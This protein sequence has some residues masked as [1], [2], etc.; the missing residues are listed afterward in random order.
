MEAL[1]KVRLRSWWTWN[2]IW[3]QE[4]PKLLL[5]YSLLFPRPNFK[6]KLCDPRLP[7][8]TVTSQSPG[9]KGAIL[10]SSYY[11]KLLL[12]SSLVVPL[13]F[14]FTFL[15]YYIPALLTFPSK[16]NIRMFKLCIARA[17]FWHVE[18]FFLNHYLHTFNSQHTFH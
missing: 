3:S 17:V 6:E 18:Y 13:P 8:F 14:Y 9:N 11:L 10:P 16:A 7:L 4:I 2:H 1:G 15:S 5:S 12:F